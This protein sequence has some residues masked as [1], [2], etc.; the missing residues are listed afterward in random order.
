MLREW[1]NL[2]E[3]EKP[4]YLRI[5]FRIFAELEHC[6]FSSLEKEHFFLRLQQQIGI[7]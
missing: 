3:R 5:E 1:K 6:V 4:I 7:G 2:F